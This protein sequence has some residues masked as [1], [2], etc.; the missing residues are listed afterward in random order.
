MFLDSEPNNI[1]TLFTLTLIIFIL[2]S[3]FFSIYSQENKIWSF[4]SNDEL[5]IDED[6][7]LS[8]FFEE[9][10]EFHIQVI[11]YVQEPLLKA[12]SI[13]LVATITLLSSGVTLHQAGRLLLKIYTRNNYIRE[14]IWRSEFDTFKNTETLQAHFI[15]SESKLNK[16]NSNLLFFRWWS[17]R[18]QLF[19]THSKDFIFWMRITILL[20]L[21]F[22]GIQS[23]EYLFSI[24]FGINDSVFGSCFFM[25]TGMHGSHVLLGLLGLYI[26]IRRFKQ[27]QLDINNLGF[28]TAVWYWHFVDAVWLFVFA[29]IY[30]WS[31]E[32]ITG[33]IV[34]A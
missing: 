11:N 16:T 7:L 10:S 13:P 18:H 34:V 23:Y 20:G 4:F 24:P 15:T 14:A 25:L 21:V 5:R 8:N 1:I 27:H 2:I 19:N 3:Y 26:C 31:G 12:N 9:N 29:I 28:I 22:V 17:L 30:W 32:A 33:Y 6:F